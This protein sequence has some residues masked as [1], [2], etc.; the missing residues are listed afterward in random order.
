MKFI[1]KIIYFI[2]LILVLNNCSNKND[3]S[4]IE[5]IKFNVDKDL[6]EQTFTDTISGIS[7]CP[8]I[9]WKPVSQKIMSRIANAHL[10]NDDEKNA[11]VQLIPLQVFAEKKENANCFLSKLVSGNLSG[12]DEIIN[13]FKK[14]VQNK[15]A[16]QTMKEGAFLIK[17]IVAYQ[18][19]IKQENAIV[20]KL[21]L[22]SK[23][24][25]PLVIDYIIPI[26]FY[27]KNL[28]AVESSIGSI[29]NIQTQNK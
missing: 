22:S 8:P 15:F 11:P 19:I 4:Q 26:K 25:S 3:F 16:D 9:H 10:Q 28:K 29:K 20:L 18:F 24:F 6:L 7:F 1:L 14:S 27:K 12:S 17:D 21:L 23:S 2:L 5:E 13:S